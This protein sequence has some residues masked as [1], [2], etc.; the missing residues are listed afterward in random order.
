MTQTNTKQQTATIAP[1]IQIALTINP[2]SVPPNGRNWPINAEAIYETKYTAKNTATLCPTL[3]VV[4]FNSSKKSPSD[5]IIYK[6]DLA[7]LF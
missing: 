7:P 1:S 6:N 4:F 3:I 5:K 2:I